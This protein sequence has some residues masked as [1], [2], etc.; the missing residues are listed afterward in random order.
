[1]WTAFGCRLTTATGLGR[2]CGRRSA[3]ASPRRPA[4]GQPRTRVERV[5]S[6]VT[7]QWNERPARSSSVGRAASPIT[8]TMEWL[9]NCRRAMR[10]CRSKPRHYCVDYQ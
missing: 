3:A 1:M 7:P 5:L 8:A 6:S 9:P 4:S 2:P 10:V